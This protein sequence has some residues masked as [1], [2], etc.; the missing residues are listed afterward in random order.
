MWRDHPFSQRNKT[1][2][3]PVGVELKVNREGGLDKFEKGW[4]DYIGG[5]RS[6]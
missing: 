6:S 3:R 2:K 5:G 4:V 1:T